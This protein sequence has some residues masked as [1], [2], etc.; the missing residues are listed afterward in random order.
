MRKPIDDNYQNIGSGFSPNGRKIVFYS[1]RTGRYDVW[2]AD[3][4]GSGLKIVDTP[5]GRISEV[6]NGD[7]RRRIEVFGIAPDDRSLF[8]SWASTQADLWMMDLG[9]KR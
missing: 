3:V 8:V 7:S 9:A 1:N 6:L 4:D 5:N 2:V